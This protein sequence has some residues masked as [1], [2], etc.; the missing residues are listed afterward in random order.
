MMFF[1]IA[2][3]KPIS[4]I[5]NWLKPSDLASQL[6]HGLFFSVEIYSLRNFSQ[7]KSTHLKIFPNWSTWHP[8]YTN[9]TTVLSQFLSDS[10]RATK[11]TMMATA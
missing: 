5:I 9:S 11:S 10:Q 8:K 4:E 6:S 7:S 1:S 3:Y 2:K